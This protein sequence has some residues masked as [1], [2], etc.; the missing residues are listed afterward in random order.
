MQSHMKKLHEV[1]I[2]SVFNNYFSSYISEIIIE[3]PNDS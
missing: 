1:G 2:A 3:L